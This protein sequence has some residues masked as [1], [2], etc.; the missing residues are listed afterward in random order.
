LAGFLID[1]TALF[2]ALCSGPQPEFGSQGS[3]AIGDHSPLD[4]APN[5]LGLTASGATRGVGSSSRTLNVPLAVS[6]L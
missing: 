3:G 4:A 1:D 2:A 6:T 5:P